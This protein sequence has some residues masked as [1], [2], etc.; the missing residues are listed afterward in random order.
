MAIE[1]GIQQ[2]EDKKNLNGEAIEIEIVNPESVGIETED[3]GI[4]IDFGG[5]PTGLESG[6]GENL[7]EILD[8]SELD[9]L[10]S[11]IVSDFSADKESRADW[12][13]TYIKGLDQLGLTVDERTEPWPGACG[14]FHPLL[15]EAVIRFQ[16]QAISEIFP[17]EGPVKT[18]I[19]GTINDEKEKQ[20]NRIQEYMNYLLTE[21]MVEYRTETEK[22][23][24]SL[25]LAGS[26]FRK[27]YYDSNMGRPCSIFVPAEDFVV[28]YGAS[29]LLTCERATHV[30]KKTEN[31]IK[32]LM[33]SG[34]FKEC[35]LP[36]PSPDIDEITDK[37]N[38]LTGESSVE[39][40]ND[41]RYT[42]LEMQVDLDLPG[43]EDTVN[44]EP[45]G[46]ALPYIVTVDK[47]SAKVLAIRR[48]YEEGDPKKRRIQHFVHYQY[49]P[50]IGF[51]GFGL[52]HMIG[53]LSRSATSLLRQLIDA[54]TLSNLPGGLKTRGL[55]IK[56]DDT[57]IM[58]GEF[59]DVDVPG[60][61]IAENISFLPYKEP[62]PTLYQLLTTIVDEG[63]R[64]ASLGDLKIADMNNEA[65]VG[66]TLALMERQ[67]KVMGAIQSRLHAAMHKE[68]TILTDIIRD[69]TPPEYPY[70]EDPDE[71]LKSEDFDGRVDVIPV[72]NPNAATMSQRIMQYQAALQLAQQAPDMYDMPELHRQMLEV[73]GIENVDKVIPNP[74]D[75]KP[76][77][78]VTENMNFL[79]MKPNKAFEF[80]DHEAHIAVHMAGMQDPEFQEQSQQSA[81]SGVI[82]MAIDDHIREH[83]AF[84][85]REEIENELGTP[86][87][88]IG[89]PLPAD[90]EK[91]LSD[92]VAQAAEKLTA[93]KQQ[94]AQQQQIQ[95][96]L[97][98]PIIQ[99]RNR[100][101]DIQ[102]GELIRKA[103]ADEEKAAANRARIKAD[104]MTE[105]R[106]IE[107]DE[108]IEGAKIGQKIGDALLEAAMEG[109]SSHSK[110]F[111]EGIRLAIE[112]QRE[113]SKKGITE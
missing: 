47:S 57:P 64:F 83:L 21:K 24:F 30:M 49:L 58:P 8:E 44:G 100:E 85:Y 68:F 66:T 105:L 20:A 12:E 71:F 112:I 108:K 17:A 53:G 29:D 69:F 102:E 2:V 87:P 67:M 15:S 11:Q 36:N 63:R 46:I 84:Q 42:I 110:E 93:R 38:K 4:E 77:D 32:K 16:S 103:K 92:L 5:G 10:G 76:T 80:Q 107:S 97:E 98:D 19:L 95:E 89:E 59:R 23:L 45:T 34:F 55:R 52:I 61:T 28:S 70:Y 94:Q 1:K 65:P 9:A 106:R 6:F 25:P 39:Y 37:Y 86:L 18:K 79:N 75:F 27:V 73:L 113:L 22:L 109:E 78:P 56:G 62:S 31:E 81:S 96:Q 26:A 111:A 90:V 91:R 82:M 41:G 48:N 50:G 43:F 7:A 13:E 33:Y 72:S 35:D 88:P 101:L 74:D 51:Y 54:G 14:V 60:G 40:D 3:G 99:Q 104:V